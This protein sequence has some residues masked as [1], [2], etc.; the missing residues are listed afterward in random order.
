MDAVKWQVTRRI[1]DQ[2]D[3]TNGLAKHVGASFLLVS[4]HELVDEMRPSFAAID[5]LQ[6]IVVPVGPGEVRTYTLYIARDFKGYPPG[7]A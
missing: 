5:R 7:R 6:S 4:E 2:W 1:R 3:L